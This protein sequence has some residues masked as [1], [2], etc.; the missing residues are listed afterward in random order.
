MMP[1]SEKLRKS[2][3]DLVFSL[4]YHSRF[5]VFLSGM[6]EFY[7]TIIKCIAL[8]QSIIE[9]AQ[10]AGPGSSFVRLEPFRPE[11]DQS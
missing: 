7:R 5:S 2:H 1:S 8:R 6:V 9:F 11:H 3:P 10:Q 4:V